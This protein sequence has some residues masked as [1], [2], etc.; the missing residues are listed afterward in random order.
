MAFAGL[1][2]GEKETK[3]Q[4]RKEDI[5]DKELVGKD[6]DFEP[7][8]VSI[9]SEGEEEATGD[10]EMKDESDSLQEGKQIDIHDQEPVINGDFPVSILVCNIGGLMLMACV[11][12]RQT[13]CKERSVSCK[14]KYEVSIEEDKIYN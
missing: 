8:K 14:P 5:K 10:S 12:N 9:K 1:K 4:S 6:E 11:D 3:G 2:T 13:D 7:D